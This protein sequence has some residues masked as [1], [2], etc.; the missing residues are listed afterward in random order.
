MATVD[1]IYV[2]R[3][4]QNRLIQRITPPPSSPNRSY[5]RCSRWLC[6]L[7]MPYLVPSSQWMRVCDFLIRSITHV[8]HSKRTPKTDQRIPNY[9][10]WSAST[11][12]VCMHMCELEATILDLHQEH[13]GQVANAQRENFLE[14]FMVDVGT[15]SETH[16][17]GMRQA[18]DIL[19]SS[20]PQYV[21]PSQK[22]T[23]P[24]HCAYGMPTTCGRDL[25]AAPL[26]RK[27]VLGWP[28]RCSVT[29]FSPIYIGDKF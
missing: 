9:G 16:A 6:A 5:S 4:Y 18:V 1:S 13:I 20:L 3:F 29:F 8:A 14:I 10:H 12:G 17:T 19:E 21:Y 23:L 2:G 15:D 22:I 26:R 11:R 25:P 28:A 7:F 24:P 27:N